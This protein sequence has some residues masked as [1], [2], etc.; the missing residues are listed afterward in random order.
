MCHHKSG[1]FKGGS[2]QIHVNFGS[3]LI[4]TD[5]ADPFGGWLVVGESGFLKNGIRSGTCLECIS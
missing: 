3:A 2:G 5:L 4:V 1:L